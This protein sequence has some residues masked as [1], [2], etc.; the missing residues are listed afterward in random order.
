MVGKA[1]AWLNE[2]SA[3]RRD[4][5]ASMVSNSSISF[6]ENERRKIVER[7]RME[8]E[9]NGEDCCLIKK[10]HDKPMVYIALSMRLFIPMILTGKHARS[11]RRSTIGKDFTHSRSII[12]D[13]DSIAASRQF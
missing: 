6:F 9:W 4:R 11:T 10:T 7:E 12:L 1:A 3:A 5:D 8:R 13:C 2:P